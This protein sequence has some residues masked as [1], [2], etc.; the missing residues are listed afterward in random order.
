[1]K[2]SY[3]HWIQKTKFKQQA[4]LVEPPPNY[5]D[6]DT[7]EHFFYNEQ[8]YLSNLQDRFLAHGGKFKSPD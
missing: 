7:P 8:K 6:K 4:I 5:K 3:L 2:H 1:M